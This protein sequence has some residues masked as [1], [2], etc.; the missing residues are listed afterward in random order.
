MTKRPK[1]TPLLNKALKRVKA[2]YGGDYEVK[3]VE[4]R[5]DRNGRDIVLVVSIAISRLPSGTAAMGAG[6]WFGTFIRTAEREGF[7]LSLTSVYTDEDNEIIFL[8]NGTYTK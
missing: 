2:S 5:P 8:F 7:N 6:A 1:M 4:G 3:R